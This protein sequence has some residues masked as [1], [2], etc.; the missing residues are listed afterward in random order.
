M[1]PNETFCKTFLLKDMLIT[2]SC[3]FDLYK[4]Y[5]M[6]INWTLISNLLDMPI[7][8]FDLIMSVDVAINCLSNY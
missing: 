1:K 7:P 3:L 2:D 8:N 4:K 5:Q 6:I